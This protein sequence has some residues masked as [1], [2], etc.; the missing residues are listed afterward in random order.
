[1]NSSKSVAGPSGMNKTLGRSYTIKPKKQEAIDPN[2]MLL[3]ALSTTVML[4][5]NK[6]LPKEYYQWSRIYLNGVRDE[7]GKRPKNVIGLLDKIETF[8]NE[9]NIEDE[10]RDFRVNEPEESDDEGEGDEEPNVINLDDSDNELVVEEAQQKPRTKSLNATT[11]QKLQQTAGGKTRS[12]SGSAATGLKRVT[13]NQVVEVE[14]STLFT[15]TTPAPPPGTGTSSNVANAPPTPASTQ[16]KPSSQPASSGPT[17]LPVTQNPTPANAPVS[18]SGA[19]PNPP[20]MP[21]SLFNQPVSSVTSTSQGIT[22]PTPASTLASSTNIPKPPPMPSSN[23]TSQPAL[24]GPSVSP[25]TPANPSA[26]PTVSSGTPDPT[27]ADPSAST[28]AP[29]QQQSPSSKKGK[30]GKPTKT[31]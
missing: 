30:T 28:T 15:P 24:S 14:P 9:N 21:P 3:V 11:P 20:P 19:I 23:P 16:P 13:I 8:E 31:I 29:P 25:V 22:N 7:N 18:S 4:A 6:P 26:V 5:K 10:M 1:M 17:A 27:S 12:A 2:H